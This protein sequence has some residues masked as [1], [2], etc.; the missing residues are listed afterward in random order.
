MGKKPYRKRIV[1]NLEVCA[2]WDELADGTSIASWEDE[3]IGSF[4]RSIADGITRD[5]KAKSTSC[6]V[7]LAFK[8]ARLTPE[9]PLNWFYVLRAFSDVHFNRKPADC[10]YDD[11]FKAVLWQRLKK[12][13][14]SQ[15][16]RNLAAACRELIAR[17]PDDYVTSEADVRAT[18]RVRS[19][20][21]AATAR[22]LRYALV[23]FGWTPADFD[24]MSPPTVG[25]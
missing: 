24:L 1:S 9:I 6:S 20:E 3:D 16:K 13:V 23:D 12:I 22:R 15:G 8:N 25:T 19:Q 5:M 21:A 14:D 17:Y 10:K 7:A 2:E 4:F 18:S 11:A